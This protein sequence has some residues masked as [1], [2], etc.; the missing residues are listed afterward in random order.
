M[1]RIIKAIRARLPNATAIIFFGSRVA[2][3]D[4]AFSDY[5]VMVVLPNGL[6]QE[7]RMRVKKKLQ[8][9]FPNVKLDLLFGSERWLRAHL[10]YEP[11]YRFWLKNSLTTWGEMHIKRFPPLAT[12][13]MKSYIEILKA[14]IDLATV[15]DD[16]RAASRLGIEALELLVQIDQAF[17]HDYSIRSVK[18]IV[19]ALVG[20]DLARRIRDPHQTVNK[21]DRDIVVR[22][23]RYKYRAVK[24]MLETM[25]ENISDRRWRKKWEARSRANRSSS[26][27][28]S[29]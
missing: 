17:K 11:F 13:A 2:G 16:R 12:G 8:A 6:E 24:S 5:D 25:P 22:V 19:N 23:A 21:Q 29:A 28:H 27:A 9:E 15:F 7:E 20:A 26:L 18:G 3:V 10:P 1:R 4:D 14:E